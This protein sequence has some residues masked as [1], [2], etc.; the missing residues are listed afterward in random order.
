[1]I[2]MKVSEVEISNE[3]GVTLVELLASIVLITL[4]LTTFIT[5]F[6]QS[7]KT[8][9]TSENIIDA[10]YVA[11]AEMEKIYAVSVITNYGERESAMSEITGDNFPEK[12]GDWLVYK[13][14]KSEGN[15]DIKIKL[16]N[17][18]ITLDIE[19][20]GGSRQVETKMN[21]I[22]VEV[23]DDSDHKE[24]AKMQGILHWGI[25]RQ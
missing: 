2:L 8:Y 22:I 9:K 13:D 21:R 7:A 4:I 25:D 20:D 17:D 10:T 12:E 19:N 11:Q 5:V 3:H 15:Y 23:S 1:M 18:P 6:I 14:E 24:R 16:G